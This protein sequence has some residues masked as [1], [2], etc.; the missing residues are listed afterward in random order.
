MGIAQKRE[1]TQTDAKKLTGKE[2]FLTDVTLVESDL[3]FLLAAGE[4]VDNV[5]I[6]ESLFQNIEDLDFASDEDDDNDYVPG[7]SDSDD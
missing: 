5:K 3:K 2:Q 4:S 6:D 1:K 7:Q